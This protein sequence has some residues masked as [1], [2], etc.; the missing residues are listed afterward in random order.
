MKFSG[1]NDNPTPTA[2]P[3]SLSVCGDPGAAFDHLGKQCQPHGHNPAVLVGQPGYGLSRN[4][5]LLV[6]HLCPVVRQPTDA[7]P[8]SASTLRA[9][10]WSNRSTSAR[11]VPSATG[12]PI[13]RPS[14]Q[15]ASIELRADHQQALQVGAVAGPQC[16]GQH[17]IV[18]LRWAFTHC[19]NWSSTSRNS[20]RSGGG[21]SKKKMRPR[22]ANA[23]QNAAGP[24]VPPGGRFQRAI[25]RQFPQVLSLCSNR[26]SVSFRVA[27]R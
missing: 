16:A 7:R 5:A 18:S 1:R 21:T 26:C 22:T 6:G 23:A 13:G 12:R 3:M 20:F 27:A 17:T 11:C 4:S 9:W 2:P 15:T 19:S 8:N 24:S 10:A 25:E 14:R